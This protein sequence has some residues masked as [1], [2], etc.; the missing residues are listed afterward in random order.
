M[1]DA[2]EAVFAGV[3]DLVTRHWLNERRR[4]LRILIADDSAANRTL[5]VRMVEGRGHSA[6]EAEDGEAVLEVVACQ[7][8]DVILLDLHMPR[9]DGFTAASHIRSLPEANARVPII[10]VSGSVSDSGRDRC[11]ELGIDDFVT[12]PFRPEHILEIIERVA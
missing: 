6:I 9:L 7:D 4:S 2:V 1:A 8:V 11:R 12:K 10:A 3:T 5:L